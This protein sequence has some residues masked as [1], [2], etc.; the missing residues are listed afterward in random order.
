MSSL[1]GEYVHQ[2]LLPAD[3]TRTV[4]LLSRQVSQHRADLLHELQPAES[5]G[6]DGLHERH[7]FNGEGLGELPRS[8]DVEGAAAAQ[9]QPRLQRPG[10]QNQALVVLQNGGGH[11]RSWLHGKPPTRE[12]GCGRWSQSS[13]AGGQPSSAAAFRMLMSS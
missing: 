3:G 5:P 8:Q 6:A 13:Q 11:E 9:E 2:R 12:S 1:S 10:R 7:Q 4:W